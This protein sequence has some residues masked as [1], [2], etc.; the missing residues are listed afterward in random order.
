MELADLDFVV[1]F[2][3][4]TETIRTYTVGYYFWYLLGYHENPCVLPLSEEDLSCSSPTP[5]FPRK[6]RRWFEY[7]F[8]NNLVVTHLV[9]LTGV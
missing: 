3:K 8:Q 4:L 9:I 1:I 6:P 2:K 5:N 7:S